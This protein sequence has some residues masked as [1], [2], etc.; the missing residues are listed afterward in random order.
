MSIIRKMRKA[1]AVIMAASVLM[2]GAFGMINGREA[3]A[4]GRNIPLKKI[5]L[6]KTKADVREGRSIRLKVKYTSKNTT[7]RKTVKWTSSRKSVAT[8]KNG[9]VIARKPG[10]TTITA[11]VGNKKAKCR[12]TVIRGL[13]EKKPADTGIIYRRETDSQQEDDREES[14]HHGEDHQDDEEQKSDQQVAAEN[15]LLK[16]SI[17]LFKE[18]NKNETNNEN[19]LISPDSI[20]TLMAMIESG[21]KGKT[22]EEMEQ[23]TYGIRSDDINNTLASVHNRLK[24]DTDSPYTSANSVWARDGMMEIREDFVKRNKELHDASVCMRPFDSDTVKEINKWAYDNTNGKFSEVI[25][26][27]DI[28]DLTRM[29]LINAV[30]FDGKWE[31]PFDE[32]DIDENGIF[33]TEK[34]E[35]QNAVMME[36]KEHYYVELNGGTG[37]V[38]PY[39]GNNTAF[40]GILP[41]EDT[42]LDDY[43]AGLDGKDF[44]SAWNSRKWHSNVEIKLPEFEYDFDVEMTDALKS[45]G[46]RTAFTDAADFTGMFVPNEVTP[47]IHIDTIFHKAHIKVDKEGTKAEAL[48]G[49][50]M[51]FESLRSNDVLKVELDRP[52]VYAIVDT[53]TGMPLFMGA[54]RTM[55]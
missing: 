28:D 30:T 3:F 55:S 50:V 38:K 53:D 6:S 22:L 36:S 9:K 54:V 11:K 1:T 43:I 27:N 48:T 31:D 20:L 49:A 15:A 40:V 52:F 51:V 12:V 5:T 17:D 2:T 25:S 8:V 33:A 21:A 45:L 46:V 29:V 14:D 24:K 44:I 37:F 34:G 23:F 16:A 13:V 18:I 39:K 19:V 47:D 42:D 4:A 10:K 7:V 26:E 41:P 32:D 35:K